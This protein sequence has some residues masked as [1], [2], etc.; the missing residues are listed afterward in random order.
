MKVGELGTSSLSGTRGRIIDLVRRAPATVTEIAASLDLTYNAVRSHLTALQRDGIVRTGRPRRGGTRPS[1]VYELAPGVD[2]ALS[3]AYMPFAS[4]LVR[5]LTDTLP[6]PQLDEIMRVVGRGL[7]TEW[8]APRGTISERVDRASTL[9]QELGAPN[10]VQRQPGMLRI[11]GVGCLLAAAVHGKPHVCR[12]ME[13][14][15]GAFIAAP[16]TECCDRGE[17][18]RCC[19][20]VEL[21]A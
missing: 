10:E 5:T 16:V 13:A 17:R 9:L 20:E 12:A 8:P 6:G 19:F 3:R 18:P 11:R 15:L 14:L 4:H 2:D 21:S 1:A 7:A